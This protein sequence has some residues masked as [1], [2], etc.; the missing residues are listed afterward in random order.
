MKWYSCLF[1]IPLKNS[2]QTRESCLQQMKVLLKSS[3]IEVDVCARMEQ[4]IIYLIY[5]LWRRY[6]TLYFSYS[7]SD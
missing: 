5:I 2:E 6:A 1:S 7:L 4:M 3:E